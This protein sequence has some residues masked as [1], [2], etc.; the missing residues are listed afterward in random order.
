MAETN[1]SVKPQ[2]TPRSTLMAVKPKQMKIVIGSM[3]IF[4]FLLSLPILASVVWLLYM[5][6]YDC[7]ELLRLPKL[8][9]GIGVALIF[10]FLVSN[11]VVFLRPRMPV[12]GFLAA[13]VVLI[14]MFT[15]GLALLGAYSMESRKVLGSPTWLK[16]KVYDDRKWNSIKS[17]IYDTGVCKNLVEKTLT[18]KSYDLSVK[19]LSPIEVIL[20]SKL[21]RLVPYPL[22]P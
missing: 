3:A 11:A 17:C 21:I 7:E 19:K 8:Q 2:E 22:K 12:M 13:M 9:I 14:V 4:T 20:I 5:R 10:V 15:A 6:D 18:V 1:Q 16:A